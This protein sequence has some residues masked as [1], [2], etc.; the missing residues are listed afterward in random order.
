MHIYI[1]HAC[2]ALIKVRRVYQMLWNWSLEVAEA[3]H[4]E[5]GIEPGS[6]L[7]A[8]QALDC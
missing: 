6:S 4:R 1:Y 8:T 7:K 5:L 3:H 2:L